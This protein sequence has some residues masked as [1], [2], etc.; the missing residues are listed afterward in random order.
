MVP[1]APANPHLPPPTYT[2]SVSTA[3]SSNLAAAEEPFDPSTFALLPLV[4]NALEA[5]QRAVI[6]A[7]QSQTSLPTANG[8]DSA[9]DEADSLIRTVDARIRDA[10]DLVRSLPGIEVSQA[11]QV[12]ALR[13][14]ERQLAA[15]REQL[16]RALRQQPAS[17]LGGNTDDRM[18]IG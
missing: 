9:M 4:V 15:R 13:D 17:D 14:A 11:A 12:A 18:D 6:A 10:H 7:Q 3:P 16:S 2:S 5:L 8:S 1:D